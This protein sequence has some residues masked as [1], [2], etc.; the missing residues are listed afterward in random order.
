MAQIEW[1]DEDQMPEHFQEFIKDCMADD[2]L[3]KQADI[4]ARTAR[5]RSQ[6]GRPGTRTF[7]SKGR[8]TGKR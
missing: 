7:K 3:A 5:P 6:G 1:P 4:E 8:K 2:P